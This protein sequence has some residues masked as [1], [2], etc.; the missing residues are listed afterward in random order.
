MREFWNFFDEGD[1]HKT[2]EGYKS[3]IKNSST[4]ENN[5]DDMV[6]T[7]LDGTNIHNSLL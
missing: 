3:T 7:L 2:V 6:M 5:N 4:D 1:D